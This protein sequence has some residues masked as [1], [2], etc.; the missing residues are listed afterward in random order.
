MTLGQ[1]QEPSIPSF[2]FS[3]KRFD[4]KPSLHLWSQEELFS[5]A[6]SISATWGTGALLR[7]AGMNWY[8]GAAKTKIRGGSKNQTI[9]LRAFS[10]P[11]QLE[12]ID[13]PL[14]SGQLLE[15]SP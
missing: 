9:I 13:L 10:R 12:E 1:Q 6:H 8:Q 15:L 4:L 11:A 14:S 3:L 7:P 5:S 2:A